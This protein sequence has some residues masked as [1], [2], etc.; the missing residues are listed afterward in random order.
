MKNVIIFAIVLNCLSILSAEGQA[1]SLDLQNRD[2]PR[3]LGRDM[4]HIYRIRVPDDTIMR[5]G[6]AFGIYYENRNY[7]VSSRHTFPKAV[8]GEIVNLQVH[9]NDRWVPATGA[10]IWLHDDDSVDIAVFA[11]SGAQNPNLLPVQ[12]DGAVIVG[13]D[14]YMLG[15]PMGLWAEG[16]GLNSGRPF[17]LLRKVT[18]VGVTSLRGTLNDQLNIVIFDGQIVKGF[19]GGPVLFR[20][21]TDSETER[22]HVIGVIKGGYFDEGYTIA[23]PSNYILEIIEANEP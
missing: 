9:Q 18:A 1:N 5:H 12:I 19:S 13:D 23:F 6:T 8:N 21:M 17:P 16:R 10:Q 4:T 15:F 14:G 3:S 2:V 11:L 7:W 20:N 22:L